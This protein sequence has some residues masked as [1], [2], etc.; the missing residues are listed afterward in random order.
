MQPNDCA[1]TG[2]AGVRVC[3]CV[4]GGGTRCGG[5]AGGRQLQ[6]Q[7]GEGARGGA[8]G[9][10]AKQGRQARQARHGSRKKAHT[11]LL[12]ALKVGV[13]AGGDDGVGGQEGG[14]VRLDANGAHAWE[15]GGG[16]GVVGGRVGRKGCRRSGG[17]ARR[18]RRRY[19]RP[20]ASH[21]RAPPPHTHAQARRPLTH[22]GRRRRGG[23]RRSCGG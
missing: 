12:V 20:G 19:T 5:G 7:A 21:A 23:C 10:K 4:G 18:P 13:G 3:V 2:G 8:E 15:D 22:P 11:H 14:Q 9:S 1:Q 6:Q 17:R 16:G